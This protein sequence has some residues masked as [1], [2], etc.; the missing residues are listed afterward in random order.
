M[1]TKLSA[2]QNLYAFL[3]GLILCLTNLHTAGAV[4]TE[5]VQVNVPTSSSTSSFLSVSYSSEFNVVAT[6]QPSTG[7]TI[8]RSVDNGLT[9]VSSTYSGGTFGFIYDITSGTI[10]GT[11]Y[12]LGI[13]DGGIVYRSLDSGVT[14]TNVAT[15]AMSG[16]GVSIGT[17][18]NA[19]V[20]GSSWRVYMSTSASNYVTWTA[21]TPTGITPSSNFYDI[22]TYDGTKVIAVAYRGYIYYS[23][24]AGTS[25]TKATVGIPAITV[26]VYCVDHGSADV[27]MVRTIYPPKHVQFASF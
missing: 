3:C 25:W 21:K 11:T 24:N 17:N 16:Y 4:A 22:S 18:G 26:I 23:S 15:V 13:D 20:A 7:S 19:Y 10:G 5:W 12:F 6:A 27:A 8:L 1:K 9:W 2:L 14:W